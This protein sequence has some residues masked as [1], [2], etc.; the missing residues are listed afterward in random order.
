M[1]KEMAVMWDPVVDVQCERTKVLVDRR[2]KEQ[3]YMYV[4]MKKDGPGELNNVKNEE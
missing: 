4:N 2:T 3:G 1:V